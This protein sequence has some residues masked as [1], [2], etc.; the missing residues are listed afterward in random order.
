LVLHI[1]P[2]KTENWNK[3]L[4]EVMKKWVSVINSIAGYVTVPLI[5]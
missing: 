1:F 3:Q 2:R 4:D 5:L